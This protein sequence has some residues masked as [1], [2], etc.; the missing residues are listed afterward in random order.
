MRKTHVPFVV[1]LLLVSCRSASQ[2][3]WNSSEPSPI[4]GNLA[5]IEGQAFWAASCTLADPACQSPSFPLHARIS[6]VGTRSYEVE[7]STP[8]GNFSVDLDP[9]DYQVSVRSLDDV[10]VTC[11]DAIQLS[12][13]PGFVVPVSVVCVVPD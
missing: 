5:R 10:E 1:L 8:A 6:I 13:P 4:S 11:P 2:G 12:A 9:G 3:E 7:T